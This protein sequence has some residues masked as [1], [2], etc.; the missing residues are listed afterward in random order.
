MDATPRTGRR[1]R[2]PGRRLLVLAGLTGFAISQPLLSVLGDE[3]DD[4]RVARHRGRRCSCCSSSRSR[5]CRRWSCGP[6]A[7][8]VE[9]RSTPAPAAPLYLRRGGA[10]VG[11]L[12][13]CRSPRRSGIEQP[14]AA[15][16]SSLAGAASAFA[17]AHVRRPTPVA[18]WASYTAVPARSSRSAFFL[19]ASPASAL[20]EPRPRRPEADG[21]R[22]RPP[23]GRDHRPRRAAH[24][25]AARRGRA[26]RPGALPE[27][28]A[29]SPTTRPGTGTTR[30]L[31][32]LTERRRAVAAHRPAPDHGRAALYA[33]HPDNLFTL[34]APTHELEVLE[35]VT[36]LCPYDSCVATEDRRHG[37]RRPSTSARP[38]FGDLLG[39]HRRPVARPRVARP[40]RA[41]RPRRLRRGGRRA[42]SRSARTS[43]SMTATE[44]TLGAGE[45]SAA[46]PTLDPGPDVHR[47]RSTPPR[48]RRSTTCTSCSRTSRGRGSPTASSTSVVDP[49]G[50]DAA[51]GRPEVSVL[52]ER[53]DRRGERAA[54]PPPGPVHRPAGRARSWTGSAPRASTTT[55][56]WSSPPTTAS[57][58]SRGRAPATSTASTVDAI[59]Y[60]PLLVKAPGQQD[61][62]VDDANVMSFDLVPT[63]AD[64]R[65]RAVAVGGRRRPSSAPRRSPPG[66]TQADRTTSAGS[67]TLSLDE[68]LEWRR[69]RRSSPALGDRWIGPLA[70]SADDPLSGLDALLDARS[71]IGARLDDLDHGRAAGSRP[72]RP[73]GGSCATPTTTSHRSASSPAVWRAPRAGAEVVHRDQRRGGRRIEAVDRLRRP[74]R[75]HRRAAPAGRARGRERGPR[76]CSSW[77]ARCV[78]LE[79][80][81]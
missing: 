71:L 28:G 42:T 8:A 81:G 77:T 52:V 16:P 23:V 30:A 69:R 22:R 79:V 65:R 76:R 44:A 59:A 75:P 54:P 47:A 26:D 3:P 34:L 45:E 74:R 29:P 43:T 68:I 53:L 4:A 46:R 80:A 5:S 15:R 66:A 9:R 41:R 61:G 20:A 14:V 39:R 33:N 2:R 40:R 17:V 58:S 19:I 6:R 25:I 37:R 38:G 67:A 60:T 78:E 64:A 35:S 1:G 24:P 70:R 63:I 10:L 57:R 7:P 11:L 50:D 49:V 27:P 62:A 72:H 56:S 55:R 21:D 36:T 48:A 73:A 51:R 12:R 32:P 18:T 13:A 31:A